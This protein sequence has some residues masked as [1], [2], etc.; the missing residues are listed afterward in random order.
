MEFSDFH[1]VILDLMLS[2]IIGEELITQIRA[3]KTIPIIVISAKPGID[4]KIEVLR[5]GAD[6][7][8]SKPFDVNE[9]IARVEAQLRRYMVFSNV[10]S[11]RE[12]V[13]QMGHKIRAELS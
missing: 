5:L 4:T 13:E 10:T 3:V 12:L 1:L 8:I 11:E 9:V 6:D 2:G 7:F